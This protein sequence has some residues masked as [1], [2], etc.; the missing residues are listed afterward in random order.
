M[1]ARLSHTTLVAGAD[2]GEAWT[3][4]P[5]EPDIRNG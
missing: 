2:T 5:N 1:A 4:M 3:A